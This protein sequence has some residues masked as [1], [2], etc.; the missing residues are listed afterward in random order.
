MSA[1]LDAG[2]H[3]ASSAGEH[4]GDPHVRIALDLGWEIGDLY[5]LGSPTAGEGD[6]AGPSALAPL[7]SRQQHA[8]GL[9]RV[10]AGIRAIRQHPAWPTD[11]PLPTTSL[12]RR[13]LEERRPEPSPAG[14]RADAYRRELA[15]LHERLLQALGGANR[16]WGSAYQL[17]LELATAT[18]LGEGGSSTV[19]GL[20]GRVDHLR[21]CLED[22]S[23]SLP[24]RAGQAGARALG[25]WGE[26]LAGG[27][28]GPG[29]EEDEADRPGGRRP[30]APATSRP[31]PRSLDA[32]TAALSE[33]R[34]RWRALL[35]GRVTAED[36]L[37]QDSHL[38]MAREV[39][40]AH[41][42]LGWAV[43]STAWLPLALLACLTGLVLALLAWVVPGD[44]AAL[45]AI[46]VAF[47][48][49]A[50]AGAWRLLSQR[51]RAAAGP[52]EESIWRT[53]LDGAVA[54]AASAPLLQAESAPR[55]DPG[56]SAAR[57]MQQ[58]LSSRPKGPGGG[59]PH[60]AG[61]ERAP[62]GR[63]RAGSREPAPAGGSR[64][65]DGV[66]GPAVTGGPSWRAPW[67]ARRRRQ[68][69]PV[70]SEDADGSQ[71]EARGSPGAGSSP[72]PAREA[73][74]PKAPSSPPAGAPEVGPGPAGT[75]ARSGGAP[76]GRPHPWPEA[77]PST[78]APP[79]PS[80]RVPVPDPSSPGAA[81]QAD[82][83]QGGQP[84]GRT[85]P[86]PGPPATRPPS[87]ADRAGSSPSPSALGPGQHAPPL[88]RI[89]AP[90]EGGVLIS[91]P[92][93]GEGR[94]PG[95][96]AELEAPA[97]GRQHSRPAGSGGPGP[98]GDDPD[99]PTQQ[100]PSIEG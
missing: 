62:A 58:Y 95:E 13:I 1:V 26:A 32:L 90:A 20:T 69:S 48:A 8:V 28:S 44:P 45:A 66:A 4:Q 17:G 41:R 30:E 74:P 98:A 27:A 19:A 31:S 25:G 46:G 91:G 7:A 99:V 36:L 22:L 84:T 10:E 93:P 9:V 51:I 43:A 76:E 29:E 68:P 47:L 77:P 97:T 2:S 23:S 83:G 57:L 87:P 55:S 75:G 94:L 38:S 61:G 60:R 85:E 24:P 64:V 35:T 59:R 3:A 80:P 100:L 70:G 15:Q 67:T 40:A 21:R 89:P 49:G 78:P 16:Q 34:Q 14:S 6:P 12:A 82:H 88:V 5:G 73:P 33:Q 65:E 39:S 52:V 79:A 53:A 63:P 54:V 72:P 56:S 92:G 81:G 11:L 37:D 50:T 71:N 18:R 86:P 42:R 96:T